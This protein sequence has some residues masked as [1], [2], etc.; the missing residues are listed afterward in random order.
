LASE[1]AIAPEH[2]REYN[3]RARHPERDQVYRGFEARSAAFRANADAA[4][5]LRYTEGERSTLDYFHAPSVQASTIGEA[6]L[7]V[8]IHGGY[9]RALDKEIFSFIAAPYVAAGAAV[10]LIGYE[11]APSVT[12]TRIV[13]NLRTAIVWLAAH[14]RELRFDPRRVVVSG[15]SAG[16]HLAALLAATD[17]ISMSGMVG[18]SGLYD[19]EPLV[20]T[21][22]N[23][24]VRMTCDEVMQLSPIKSEHF[25]ATRFLVAVGDRETAGF[26]DQSKRFATHLSRAGFDARFMSVP[27][28]THFDVLDDFAAPAAPLY[29]AV[30]D[31]LGIPA[32]A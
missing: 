30:S 28:R 22:V 19:L 2:E 14:A 11:L 23:L 10:A 17:G 27:N 1:S 15:H 32:R 9:W 12:L 4:L 6:P 25:Y 3:L 29:Q 18:L 8:F 16:G 24:D 21:S 7:L 26:I 31:F 13:A 20:H 5:N